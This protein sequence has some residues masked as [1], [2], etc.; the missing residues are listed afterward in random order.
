MAALTTQRQARA[1]GQLV[2]EDTT[3]IYCGR[4]SAPCTAHYR[5]GKKHLE[6]FYAS[7]SAFT[8]KFAVFQ[9]HNNRVASLAVRWTAIAEEIYGPS[10]I[11]VVGPV[12]EC[13]N[14]GYL[15]AGSA[16]A[17]EA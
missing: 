11:F 16:W 7:F 6:V 3:Y 17:C 13:D 9:A 8:S 12:Q 4:G 1:P 5:N 10:T 2:F 14:R 15:H